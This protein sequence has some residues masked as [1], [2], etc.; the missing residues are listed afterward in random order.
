ARLRR[1]RYGVVPA[2]VLAGA[3]AARC[4]V[5][6]FDLLRPTLWWPR[7][8]SRDPERRS[9]PRFLAV[10]PAPRGVW[11]VDDVV[12]TGSTFDAAMRVLGSRVLEGLVAT[13]PGTMDV[14]AWR[15]PGRLHSGETADRVV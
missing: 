4:G 8:A 15:P 1:A 10:A 5:P 9:A 6:V 2:R 11:L 7:H 14:P 3:V 13:A 12:R